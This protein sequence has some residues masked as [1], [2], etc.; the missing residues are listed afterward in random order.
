LQHWVARLEH[1]RDEAV[2][3]VG[4]QRYRVWRIYMAGCAHAFEHAWISIHQLLAAR[5]G[6]HGESVQPWNR[7]YM[8]Q[9]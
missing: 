9:P 4:E 5:P 3:L 8:L 7:S 6:E 1:R 2:A